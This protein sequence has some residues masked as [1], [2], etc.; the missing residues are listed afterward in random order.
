METS[1]RPADGRRLFSVAQIQH[2][3]RTE[4]GRSQRYK[5]PLAVLVVAVDQ[6]G[7]IRDRRGYESKEAV[8]EGVVKLLFESTRSSD[9]LGRTPDDRLMAVVPH[10]D[11]AG[12]RTLAERLLA[13]AR[14][15]AVGDAAGERFTLSIGATSTRD[16]EPLFPDV[17]LTAAEAAQADAVSAG[18][19]RFVAVPPIPRAP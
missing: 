8:V 14:A 6:L 2:V 4:F 11:E 5:Y 18:G 7:A 12:A 10:T 3:L 17:L 16:G 9:F 13:G 15:L 1:T 19:D